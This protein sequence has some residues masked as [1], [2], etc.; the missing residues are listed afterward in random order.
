MFH[1]TAALRFICS[2]P[3]RIVHSSWGTKAVEVPTDGWM[4]IEIVVRPENGIFLSCKI[5][6]TPP[7]AAKLMKLEDLLLNEISQT[8]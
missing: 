4:D 3:H 5:K 2:G 7:F 8:E 1:W 6:E